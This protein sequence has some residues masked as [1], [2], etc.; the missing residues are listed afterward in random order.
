MAFGLMPEA[1]ASVVSAVRKVCDK[2]LIVKLS[3]NA[4]DIIAV[5]EA[6]VNAGA[7]ALS[8]VNTFK[9]MAIDIRRC[10]PVFDNITAGLSGPAIKPIALRMVFELCEAMK[11]G[12]MKKVPVLGIGGI[13]SAEDAVEFLLAGADAVEVGTATFCRPQTMQEIV[14]GIGLYMES[15][16]MHYIEDFKEKICLL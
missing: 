2:P 4:P 8:L 5:A 16:G 13:A 10:K 3:P 1:A 9:A 7:D 12:R 14:A 6:A 11:K 15:M